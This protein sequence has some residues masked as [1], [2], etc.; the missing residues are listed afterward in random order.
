MGKTVNW[1]IIGLG[2]IAHKF[3]QDLLLVE[4]ANL[5]GVASRDIV[6]AKD[7][8]SNYHANNFYGSYKDLADDP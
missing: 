8:A 6:K 4:D 1:G 3:A 5:Y 7:F 2:K